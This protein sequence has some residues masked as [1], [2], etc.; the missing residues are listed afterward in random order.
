MGSQRI[1]LIHS[2]DLGQLHANFIFNSYVNVAYLKTALAPLSFDVNGNF[3]SR[4]AQLLL[5]LGIRGGVGSRTA[6]ESRRES[7]IVFASNLRTSS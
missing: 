2:F 3:L 4:E 5:S 1:F 7:G 6:S